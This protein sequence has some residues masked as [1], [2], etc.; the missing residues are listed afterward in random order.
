MKTHIH[1]KLVNLFFVSVIFLDFD[2]IKEEGFGFCIW[3]PRRMRHPGVPSEGIPKPWRE[4][5]MLGVTW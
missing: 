4:K 1:V 3:M 2:Q 5:K